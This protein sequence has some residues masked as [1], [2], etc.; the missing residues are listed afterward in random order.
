M[1]EQVEQWHNK[2]C[3]HLGAFMFMAHGEVFEKPG[4]QFSAKGGGASGKF[5]VR[6]NDC[7]YF[8]PYPLMVGTKY[9]E[10][11]MH[12]VCHSASHQIFPGAMWHGDF[13]KY[14]TRVVCGYAGHTTRHSYNTS[15]VKFY[16]PQAK[17]LILQREI[18][19]Y[20]K[21]T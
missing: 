18:A 17:L 16:V 2:W 13:F 21:H 12:E 3:N 6:Q 20:E 19:E 1:L 7:L 9:E 15:M 14:L 8:V 11:V 4:V 5:L 10:I